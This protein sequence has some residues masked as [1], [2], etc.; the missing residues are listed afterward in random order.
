L[1]LEKI[2]KKASE[3][4]CELITTEKDYFRIRKYGFKEIKFLELR[5]QILNEENLF[6][7]IEKCF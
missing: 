7:E 2:I 3:E 6:K 4:D 5:L 1:E